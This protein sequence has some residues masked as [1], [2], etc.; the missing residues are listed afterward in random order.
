M[1]GPVCVCVCVCVCVYTE[2][3][4]T[5]ITKAYRPNTRYTCYMY[6]PAAFLFIVVVESAPLTLYSA[7]SYYQLLA[8]LAVL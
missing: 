2:M 7:I 8:Y 6:I 5:P 3:L 1:I 4:K